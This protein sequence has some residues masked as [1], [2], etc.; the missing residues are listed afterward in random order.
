M[1]KEEIKEKVREN[2][3][4]AAGEGGC[5]SGTSGTVNCCGQTSKEN[6]E[7]AGEEIGY[8]ID[9]LAAGYG[10]ANL[11]LG[12]GNPNAFANLSLGEVVLDL[13]SGAG[14]DAFIAAR[15]VGPSGRVIGVDMTP[16]MVTKARSIARKNQIANVDFR[17]GEIEHLPVADHSI[18]VIIS[19]C[20]LNLSP[21]KETV[22]QEMKRV[23]KPGGRI[24]ISDILSRG[25]LPA[26]LR[27]DEVSY[28]NCVAG[29]I[30]RERLFGLLQENG[31]CK[32]EIEE[33]AN[34]SEIV[35]KWSDEWKLSDYIYS[36]YIRAEA[37]EQ[38]GCCCQGCD[39]DG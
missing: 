33:K 20:V 26:A 4:R 3:A 11:G 23:L 18:D 17:L 6:A 27:E 7:K 5:C 30:T 24:S 36:A 29:A 10:E 13:G 2:Y 39:C 15:E 12:C 25:N 28:C 38:S 35:G 8:Q 32:I 21:D 19:N 9:D 14:F 31:F 1:G 16:E 34:S 37:A 22:F